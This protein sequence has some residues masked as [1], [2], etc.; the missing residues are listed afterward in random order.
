MEGTA[1]LCHRDSLD[2]HSLLEESFHH[3]KCRKT[4]L[5]QVA[6]LTTALLEHRG[7]LV[8]AWHKHTKLPRLARLTDC[9]R[10][11]GSIALHKRE[12]TDVDARGR[13]GGLPICGNGDDF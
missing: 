3:R 6:I 7:K 13:I 1:Q 9:Q 10:V 8:I 12:R 11:A 5:A 4:Q 2:L